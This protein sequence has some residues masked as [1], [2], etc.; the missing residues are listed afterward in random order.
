MELDI[1]QL[2]ALLRRRFVWLAS[3]V[4]VAV[5]GAGLLGFYVLDPEYEST[6]T[7]IVKKPPASDVS[8]YDDLMAG[9][10]LLKTFEEIIRSRR[11]AKGVLD[12]LDL[13]LTQE[14]LLKKVE[15]DGEDKSLIASITVTDKDPEQA[16]R[17]ANGFATSAIRESN[18]IMGHEYVF[19]LDS[20]E[21]AAVPKPVS[22]RPFFLM[23]VAFVLALLIGVGGAVLWE[24]TDKTMKTEEQ[25]AES[26]G[27]PVL[28]T[29]PLL[30][31]DDRGYGSDSAL[32]G[33]AHEN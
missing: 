16:V 23:A 24:K 28:G 7:L 29:I 13:S 25:L 15:V 11:V 12:D 32:G 4:V 19:L 6:A 31:K 26:L 14:Q 21:L 17:I 8:V 20:A 10:Q 3:L 27:V 5:L 18:Q 2:M 30:R 33:V 9:G 1:A 22:P